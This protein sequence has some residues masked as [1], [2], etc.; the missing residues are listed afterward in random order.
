LLLPS[1]EST[2]VINVS[3]GTNPCAESKLILK[4]PNAL[5]LISNVVA[6]CAIVGVSTVTVL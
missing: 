5:K 4:V 3:P 2:V 1:S 6:S